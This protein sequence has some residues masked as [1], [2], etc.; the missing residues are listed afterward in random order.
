MGRGL[1]SPLSGNAQKKTFFV[2]RV[3]S[4][5]SKKVHKVNALVEIKKQSINEEQ[6]KNE[7]LIS[8]YIPFLLSTSFLDF[9]KYVTKA[10]TS[11]SSMTSSVTTNTAFSLQLFTEFTPRGSFYQHIKQTKVLISL[12]MCQYF[13]TYAV[14]PPCLALILAREI[15][16]EIL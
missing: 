16:F 1:P 8:F 14:A 13:P 4:W 2:G 15:N 3:P 9:A 5:P 7:N 11:V 6:I 12:D 10:C